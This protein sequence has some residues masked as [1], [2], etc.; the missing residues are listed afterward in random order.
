MIG[1]G[2]ILD[3]TL[4]GDSSS[5]HSSSSSNNIKYEKKVY[6]TDYFQ[7]TIPVEKN[8]DEVLII[9]N[10]VA[11]K[12]I[13]P[14]PLID[15]NLNES[16]RSQADI[17]TDKTRKSPLN[18]PDNKL[19]LT[20]IVPTSLIRDFT[21]TSNGAFDENLNEKI[22]ESLYEES[23]NNLQTEIQNIPLI[24]LNNNQTLIMNR[25]EFLQQ[26]YSDKILLN[27]NT[28]KIK[29][30]SG[31]ERKIIKLTGRE[32]SFLKSILELSKNPESSSSSS[33]MNSDMSSDSCT[34]SE[35]VFNSR[36][37]SSSSC[38]R[39][40][41]DWDKCQ[42]SQSPSQSSQDTCTSSQRGIIVIIIIVVISVV[43]VVVII[44]IIII[45]IIVIV[46]II[47]V[48]IITVITI[49]IIIIIITTF[50]AIT[51]IIIIL[52]SLSLLLLFYSIQHQCSL[53]LFISLYFIFFIFLLFLFFPLFY[54]VTI[55][56]L[57]Y[58][59]VL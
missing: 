50:I 12:E 57:C 4:E 47:I 7:T 5:F 36:F 15:P 16:E 56:Y 43:V 1:K 48:I 35:N 39:A 27:K 24:I 41:G 9:E 32:N 51:I 46:T 37:G 30:T 23:K 14:I 52:L 20:P 40:K 45:I 13:D 8:F 2:E 22:N 59:I 11:T 42:Q 38:I 44:I 19:N 34:A 29:E 25:I 53:I 10:V 21:E 31:H 49:I 55:L 18:R 28:E 33:F 3:L 17:E 58:I 6:L 26:K 54:P